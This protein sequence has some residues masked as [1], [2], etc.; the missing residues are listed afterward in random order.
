MI[1]SVIL[2]SLLCSE[3]QAAPLIISH[4]A[5]MGNFPQGSPAA[6]QYSI[7]LGIDF[8]ELDLRF[9]ADGVPVVYHN[10]DIDPQ[11]CAYQDGS[12]PTEQL[13]IA[14]LPLTEIKALRCGL[15]VNPQ[16]P[17]Q[18]PAP[19]HI[20]T[21]QEVLTSIATQDMSIKLMLEL[22]HVGSRKI[23]SFVRTVLTVIENSGLSHRI[24]LQ[25]A[26]PYI[27]GMLKHIAAWHKI[28]LIA[29]VVA[30]PA[31]LLP[32]RLAWLQRLGVRVVGYTVNT[33]QEWE[34]LLQADV[35]GII[36]DYPRALKEFLANR[37]KRFL[38]AHR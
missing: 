16:F 38:P 1:R 8:I 2:I 32:P 5:G 35:D 22:K 3:L 20:L 10:S 14:A 24:N 30:V 31:N 34:K 6:I 33:P 21:L 36:T 7:A 19:H 17:E 29:N 18:I 12:V 4:R 28:P 9:S 26:D 37:T 25:S 11:L 13:A 27:V 23:R 15:I